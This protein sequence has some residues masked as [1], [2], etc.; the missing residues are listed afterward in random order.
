[1]HLRVLHNFSHLG[2]SLGARHTVSCFMLISMVLAFIT[3]P[4]INWDSQQK[5]SSEGM[6]CDLL[7]QLGNNMWYLIDVCCCYPQRDCS[8]FVRF[9]IIFRNWIL[10]SLCSQLRLINLLCLVFIH[11]LSFFLFVTWSSGCNCPL[12]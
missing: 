1:M 8:C 3:A 2:L 5:R 10:W 4:T 7:L 11:F 9:K 12:L 6:Q